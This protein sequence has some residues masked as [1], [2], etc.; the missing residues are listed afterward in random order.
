M[1]ESMVERVARTLYVASHHANGAREWDNPNGITEL[2]K[3]RFRDM[4]RAVIEAMREPTAVMIERA[5]AE[6]SGFPRP[7]TIEAIYI[8]MI[9]AALSEPEPKG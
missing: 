9:D 6:V 7:R 2:A 3:P 1:T 5:V 8:H 4:A